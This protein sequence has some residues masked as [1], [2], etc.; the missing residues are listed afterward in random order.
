MTYVPLIAGIVATGVF[1]AFVWAVRGHFASVRVPYGMWVVSG[2][3]AGCFV[4][5]A[6]ALVSWPHPHWLLAVSM[7][8]QGAA[9]ALF[10]WAVHETRSKDLALAFDPARP[11][12]LVNSGPFHYIRHPFYS[13]YL[14]FWGSAA[15]QLQSAIL[16]FGI[17][18]LAALYV[19]AAIGEEREFARSSLAGTYQAYMVGR[20]RF[21]PKLFRGRP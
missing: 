12:L 21:V 16:S 6:I 13:S 8:G 5:Y 9:W 10:I 3:S 19:L 7:V 2:L 11:T 20:G 18:G 17:A 14:L 15:L 1:G 4:G